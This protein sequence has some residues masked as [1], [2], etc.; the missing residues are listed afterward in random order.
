MLPRPGSPR[1]HSPDDRAGGGPAV[2]VGQR[3]GREREGVGQQDHRVVGAEA[4]RGGRF[5]MR[6]PAGHHRAA[7]RRE[8]RFEGEGLHGRPGQAG[9]PQ[10]Q[11]GWRLDLASGT[12]H[13]LGRAPQ[14]DLRPEFPGDDRADAGRVGHQVRR[15]ED[16][17]EVRRIVADGRLHRGTCLP[18]GGARIRIRAECCPETVHGAMVWLSTA[19]RSAA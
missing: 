6:R 18:R 3:L 4:R 5:H 10:R 1:C 7:V 19:G 14:Q 8:R 12:D 11:P 2:G 17:G 13:G 16:H 9:R 15:R